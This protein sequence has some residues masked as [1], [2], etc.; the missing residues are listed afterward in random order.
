MVF[1]NHFFKIKHTIM[2]QKLTTLLLLLITFS[3]CNQ[4]ANKDNTSNSEDASASF[5]MDGPMIE[6]N[7]LSF[8]IEERKTE[9]EI[10]NRS[11]FDLT[12]I[13][14]RLF[15]NDEEGNAIQFSNGNFKSSSFSL[16]ERPF[17]VASKSKVTKTLG[18]K[19][20]GGTGHI[21]VDE[22]VGK[23]LNGDTVNP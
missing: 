4:T 6:I 23:T 19:I 11:E 18:N 21:F 3:A 15:F 1:L 14:G 16:A 8:S 9:I 10:I 13:S 20:E 2:I 12:G 17:V 7:V 22:I 5:S